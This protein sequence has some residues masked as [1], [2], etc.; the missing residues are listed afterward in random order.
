MIADAAPV[1]AAISASAASASNGTSSSIAPRS[2]MSP[3]TLPHEPDN[4]DNIL[5]KSGRSRTQQSRTV[6]E[7]RREAS[8][9]EVEQRREASARRDHLA[10]WA[11]SRPPPVAPTPN[12]S[13][14]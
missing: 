5:P 2:A 3:V 4:P 6:V 13:L 9:T 8:D 10:S 7:Q 1:Q 12:P 14:L 11:G